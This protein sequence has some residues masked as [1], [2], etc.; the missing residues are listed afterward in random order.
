MKGFWGAMLMAAGILIAGLS[1]LCSGILI[2]SGL[3]GGEASGPDALGS[4]M[5]VLIVGG[6]PFAIG[7]G[8]FFAG[9]ALA[10]SQARD[11]ADA[12]QEFK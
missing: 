10:R 5:I 6:I 9:R 12:S 3:I 1:G 4:L 11:K 8:L 7:L 2:I